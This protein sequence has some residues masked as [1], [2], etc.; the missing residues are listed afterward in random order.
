[1]PFILRCQ[2]K[3]KKTD[4]NSQIVGKTAV[5]VS[6]FY[7]PTAINRGRP[8]MLVDIVSPLNTTLTAKALYNYKV[9]GE[10]TI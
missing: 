6:L 9:S 1:M 3:N 2:F 8:V 5:T 10:V 7:F 4:R